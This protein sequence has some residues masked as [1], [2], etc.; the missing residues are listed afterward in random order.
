VAAGAIAGSNKALQMMLH[1]LFIE[2][3][4]GVPGLSQALRLLVVINLR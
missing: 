1:V 3:F 4:I 2:V